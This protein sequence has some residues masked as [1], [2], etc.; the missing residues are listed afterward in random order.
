[1][2]TKLHTLIDL[3][4]QKQHDLNCAETILYGANE[5]Y[6]LG[7]G[8]ESLKLAAGFGGGLCTEKEC[9]VVTGMVMVLSCLFA[10][11][12]GHTSPA[13]K[14]KVQEAIRLFEAEYGCTQCKSLKV[15]FRVKRKAVMT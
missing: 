4:Y 12:R 9:G 7:L 3:G 13:L 15:T 6:R 5:A 11:E 1:M 14:I 2:N 10:E 8:P